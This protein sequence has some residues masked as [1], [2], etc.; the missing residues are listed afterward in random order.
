MKVKDKILNERGQFVTL[1]SMNEVSY[2]TVPSSIAFTQG[3]S[4][5]TDVAH[6][7]WLSRCSGASG[8]RL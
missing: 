7:V 3:L 8:F 4:C 5:P 6:T 1:F 2:D